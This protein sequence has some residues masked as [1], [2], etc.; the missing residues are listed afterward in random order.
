MTKQ[1][2][3]YE[4]TIARHAAYQAREQADSAK[5]AEFLARTKKG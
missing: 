5:V 2:E 3:T 4:Q 1:T